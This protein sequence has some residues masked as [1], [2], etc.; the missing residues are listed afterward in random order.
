MP[1]P[2]LLTRAEATD[3]QETSRSADVVAF[4]DAL[5]AQTKLAKRVD[6]GQSGEGQPLMS[7]I[8][9]DRNC[10]TPELAK[11]QKK[12]IVMVEANIHAGEV[13]G[14][15][16]LQ[17]L[18]RD[19]TLTS[20]GKKL[21][22]RLCI[23]FVPNFNPDG[24]DRISKGNRALDLKNL[25]GQV[26][27]PGGVGMRYT[28][29]G[30]NL[31]RDNMKQEAPETRALAKLYQTWWPHLFV[32][33]HTTDGSIHGFDL[34]FDIPHGN[35]ELLH[36]SRDYNRELAERVSAAVKTKHGFDSFWYGN[37][38]KEG[39]PRSGW[40]TYPALPRFG[41]HYR[42][43]LGRLD[44]L[45]ET[46]SYID[47]PRR[48]AVIR[49]WV[50]E[51]IRDAA[52]YAKEYRR[53]TDFEEAAI[54]ARGQSPDV[55]QWVGINYGVAQRAT[56]GALVF[57]YPAYV[58]DGDTAVINSFD[59]ASI[60]DRRYPGKRKKVYKTPHHRT[61]VPTQAVST[62]AGYLVPASLAAR[63]DG[64]G[65]RYEKLAKAQRFQVDSYRIARKEETFSPDV[66]ANVPPPGQDEV[67]LSQKPKPVRFETILTV[68]SER[69]EQDFPAGTLL[70]GTDQR[71]GTLITYLLEPHSD[72]GF[73]R[74]QFLDDSL[75]VGELYPIHRL[76]ESTRAPQKVE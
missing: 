45:L 74:W 8:L 67:P 70:V 36:T 10:F 1:T 65:I 64:H 27:P 55:R 43:L 31:N 41:S 40:H 12:L 37:F 15:E 9:S 58:K 68:A 39:D 5:C 69:S 22:D 44:V 71:T 6:F 66:A 30:W 3:Y 59:E 53:V 56:D 20:L 50:L 76:V 60:Q 73:C 34:T 32:D 61:F 54:I 63:L 42:G 25:E 51:L 29:E 72:D 38:R 57:D 16:T 33:C 21:L 7:L 47:F 19:L 18:A 75:K 23:V 46:Y 52:R 17:A 49:A 13:E 2:K 62:P 28:G 14:K 35:A 24:N 11:K 26:N 4:V 48:C